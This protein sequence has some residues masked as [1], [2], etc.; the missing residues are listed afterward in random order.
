MTYTQNN[1]KKKKHKRDWDNSKQIVIKYLFI[2]C[3]ISQ[4]KVRQEG[5]TMKGLFKKLDRID[6]KIYD[7][8][9]VEQYLDKVE[10]IKR[11]YQAS[12]IYNQL[13]IMK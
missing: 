3:F 6:K 12:N 2:K 1:L 10:G 13:Y 5:Y 4:S 9:Q 8:K 11:D 7:L